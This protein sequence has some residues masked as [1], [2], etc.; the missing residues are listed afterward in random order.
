[1]SRTK[2]AAEKAAP[3]KAAAK[4]GGPGEMRP[5][6]PAVRLGLW[7]LALGLLAYG[8]ANGGPQSVLMK[9][10]RICAECIGLG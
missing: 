4:P 8:L 9:A 1:M 5:L 6:P 3:E 7:A 10:V 2:P